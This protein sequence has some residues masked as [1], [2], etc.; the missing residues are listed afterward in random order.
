MKRNGTAN[1]ISKL[2][3]ELKHTSAWPQTR[4]SVVCQWISLKWTNGTT[5]IP[6]SNFEIIIST[7]WQKKKVSFER[8][9]MFDKINAACHS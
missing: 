2:C 3:D 8:I 5:V 6:Q 9:K 7:E 1:V 4:N